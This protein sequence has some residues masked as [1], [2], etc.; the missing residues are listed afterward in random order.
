VKKRYVTYG[1]SPE[2][3][4]YARDLQANGMEIKFSVYHQS[5]SLGE[6]RLYMPGNASI[7]L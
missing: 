4:F 5:H 7:A 6:M 2:A 3:D 1:L